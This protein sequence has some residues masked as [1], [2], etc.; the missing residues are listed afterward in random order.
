MKI[1]Y[2]S[3]IVERVKERVHTHK[4][5]EKRRLNRQDDTAKRR[6]TKNEMQIEKLQSSAVSNDLLHHSGVEEE[7]LLDN[8]GVDWINFSQFDEGVLNGKF[9][10]VFL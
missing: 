3:E 2:T 9:I 5:N 7:E 1:M 10:E 4:Q 8:Y 6:K